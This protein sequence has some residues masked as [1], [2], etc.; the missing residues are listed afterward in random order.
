[1][2]YIATET[3]VKLAGG[4]VYFECIKQISYNDIIFN[5]PDAY[6]YMPAG[7]EYNTDWNPQYPCFGGMEWTAFGNPCITTCHYTP[8]E[9][10]GAVHAGQPLLT[11]SH[12]GCLLRSFAG[13]L[14][15]FCVHGVTP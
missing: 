4:A 3:A 11:R 10:S 14:R 12:S 7:C 15:M 5:A 6:V 1:M 2:T 8:H 9:V 13:A